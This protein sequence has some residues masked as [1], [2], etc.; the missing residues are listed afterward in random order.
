MYTT[1]I[2]ELFDNLIHSFADFPL[3]PNTVIDNEQVDPI[4]FACCY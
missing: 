4:I 2:L 1:P 3:T